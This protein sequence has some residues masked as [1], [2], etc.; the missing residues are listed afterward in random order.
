MLA[1]PA[2]FSMT[3]S[4]CGDLVHTTQ[5][6]GA[7]CYQERTEQGP[8]T[9]GQ[10]SRFPGRGREG[11]TFGGLQAI[12]ELS[13]A[14]SMSAEGSERGRAAP[15]RGGPCPFSTFQDARGEQTIF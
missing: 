12:G 15:L 3:I 13:V 5:E 10:G 7:N 9:S 11:A 14:I 8:G 2:P 1:R 4:G 6:G